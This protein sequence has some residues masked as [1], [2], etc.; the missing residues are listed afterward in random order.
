MPEVREIAEGIAG[1]ERVAAHSHITGLGL[2]G[3]KAKPIAN[4]MVG[5]I[6][7]REAAGLVVRLI[8][9]GKFAGR[10]VLIA[11][12]PS[13]GKTALAMAIAREL[14]KDVPFVPIAASEIF[15]AEVKKTEFLTQALRK[16]IG[17]RIKER[18]KIY[19]GEVVELQVEKTAHPYNPYIQIPA[20][21]SVKLATADQEKKLTMDQ[22]FATQLVQQGVE[23][24][25]VIQIDVE[26][27]RLI[28]LGRSERSSKQKEVEVS[29]VRPV[30]V[31]KG[32][33]LKDKEFV[34]VLTLHQLDMASARSG[35][36]MFSL[37]F[38]SRERLEI[39]AET[40]RSVDEQVRNW[41]GEGGA[42][43]IPGVLFIDEC[44][45]LDI[46]SIAFLNRAMEQELAPL[47]ILATN[48]GM[49]Q[50]RGTDQISPHALPIDL[51]DR[52][53]IINTK[54][55][56]KEEIRHIVQIRSKAERIELSKEAVD[57]LTEVGAKTS[58]RYAIQLIAPAAE[59]AKAEHSSK[60]QLKH[61]Q[62]VENL[63]VDVKKSVNY[64]KEF[65][66]KFLK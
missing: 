32:S 53:L 56:T 66:E 22:S 13:T 49:A 12:P 37:L 65:E 9:E 60:V 35:V 14:G 6:E 3:L 21:A 39:D 42:T 16:A 40:R 27:G 2:E 7:A 45:M 18:R 26:G 30:P 4:G 11:G 48:R 61:V 23:T 59:V 63:F 50:V 54:P 31:P 41:V 52:L 28:K 55:Y 44:S 57:Y 64:L 17:V 47:I 33:V 8:K 10:G 1:W 46:E 19:E 58:M 34:Y 15:S 36:D 43:I 51:L 20:G 25:D 62:R 24:G 5:Q 38:G 29:A